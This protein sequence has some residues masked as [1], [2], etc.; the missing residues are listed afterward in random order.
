MELRRPSSG[1]AAPDADESVGECSQGLVV[2]VAGGSSVVVEGSTSFA[3]GERAERPLVDGVVEAPIADVA[4][5]HGSFASGC[6][7]QG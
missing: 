4:G 1:T 2:E 7:G 6:D 3:G 5:Q